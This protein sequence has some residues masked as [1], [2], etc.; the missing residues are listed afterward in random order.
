MTFSIKGNV[1]DGKSIDLGIRLIVDN[2]NAPL[3]EKEKIIRVL[4]S[5]QE[6]GISISN[7]W[8]KVTIDLAEFILLAFTG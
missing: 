2:P 7:R 4:P 1:S 5:L 8:K 6:T 3:N